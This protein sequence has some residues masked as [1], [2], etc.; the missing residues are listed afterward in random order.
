MYS[1]MRPSPFRHTLAVLRTA[2]GLTQKEMAAILGC[3]TPTI[4][5]VEL[6][7]LKL[8]DGLAERIAWETGVALTWLM[9]NDVSTPPLADTGAEFTR[10]VF[11]TRQASQKRKLGEN[12]TDKL[13]TRH[14][15]AS[16]IA[17][18]A[19][20]ASAAIKQNRFQLF[21]YKMQAAQEA[22]AKEFGRDDDPDLSLFIA[23]R[24]FPQLD[25]MA[26]ALEDS[27]DHVIH[28]LFMAIDAGMAPPAPEAVARL[29]AAL[30]K[31]RALK[32][33]SKAAPRKR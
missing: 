23:Q 14:T 17:K 21:A 15:V 9:K 11:D 12:L 16:A 22:L 32:K 25:S 13:W 28:S 26:S 20:T 3:S 6:G 31:A 27:I 29:K 18:F 8:S 2:I 19:A 5:A 30:S 4:Q 7:K 1:P 10:A 33:K 24:G